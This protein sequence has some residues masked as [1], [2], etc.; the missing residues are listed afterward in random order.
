MNNSIKEKIIKRI[1]KLFALGD[2]NRNPNEAEVSTALKLAKKLLRKYNL[3]I[4]EC[5]ETEQKENI[6]KTNS[7]FCGRI[8]PWQYNL[9]NTIAKLCNVEVIKDYYYKQ[10]SGFLFVGYEL[11]AKLAKQLYD[12]IMPL[13]KIWST[14]IKYENSFSRKCY[15]QGVVQRLSDR[16]N[17]ILAFKNKPQEIKYGTLMILKDKEISTYCEKNLKLKTF[18]RKNPN[19]KD[20]DIFAYAQGYSDGN[21]IDLQD[22]QKIS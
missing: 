19:Y 10:A 1:Q 17:E 2:K 8:S 5:Q 6:I 14:K 4:A 22:K 3:T 16:V 12:M 13:I 20:F 7:E 9:A 15:L 11:E 21:K 18:Q